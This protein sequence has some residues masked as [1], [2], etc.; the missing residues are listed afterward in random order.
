[1]KWDRQRAIDFFMAN[2]P[3]AELDI[4]NEIDR[5]IAWPGQALGYKIGQ[6]KIRELRERARERLGKDY[7]IREYHDMVLRNGAVP[8]DIL[9]Q[10]VNA[11]LDSKTQ[12][13]GR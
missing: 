9:E 11:W 3:K 10:N 4:V 1:M 8:L 12:Q 6:M 2:A 13:G 7:D 5:Y